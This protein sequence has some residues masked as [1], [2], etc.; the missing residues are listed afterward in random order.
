[1]PPGAYSQW[2]RSARATRLDTSCTIRC[3]RLQSARV[4]ARVTTASRRRGS[5]SFSTTE[6][7]KTMKDPYDGVDSCRAPIG[8]ARSSARP[9]CTKWWSSQ[10][11]AFSNAWASCSGTPISAG[12]RRSPTRRAQSTRLLAIVDKRTPGS[13]SFARLRSSLIRVSGICSSSASDGSPL[14]KSFSATPRP[15]ARS[16]RNAS[17]SRVVTSRNAASVRH[18]SR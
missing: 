18:L 14:P 2:R 15:S 16:R 13:I 8:S 12:D 6:S 17:S 10:L 7:R 11:L 5:I 9:S 4:A 3:R 1:M